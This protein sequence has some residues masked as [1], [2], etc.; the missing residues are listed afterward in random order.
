MKISFSKLNRVAKYSQVLILIII[1]FL[2]AGT[3]GIKQNQTFNN[4][5]PTPVPKIETKQVYSD[6]H[7]VIPAL[8]ISAPVIADVDGTDKD[9]YF[10]A[11]EGGVA[12]YQNTSKPG[13]G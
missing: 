1:V 11:L 9:T 10:K 12:H 4:T 3:L 13:E 8:N 6:F 5:A 7:L 2:F